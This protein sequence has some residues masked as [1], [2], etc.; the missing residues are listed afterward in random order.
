LPKTGYVA[1]DETAGLP[2]VLV[3]A[4]AIIA[5][6]LLRRRAQHAPDRRRQ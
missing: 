3:G 6:V 5:G 4:G 1:V 2:A